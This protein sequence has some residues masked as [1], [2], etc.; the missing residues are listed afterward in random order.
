MSRYNLGH[1]MLNNEQKK[2]LAEDTRLDILRDIEGEFSVVYGFDHATGYF[3]QLYPVDDAAK[4]C[5]GIFGDEE[6]IDIDSLF[7]GMTGT[8]L[9]YFLKMIDENNQHAD[10]AYMD[11]PF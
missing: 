10:F 7:N 8:D 2:C 3:L 9:G 11:F 5:T 6:C 1:V 4:D